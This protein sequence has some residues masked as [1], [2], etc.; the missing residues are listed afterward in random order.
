MS[1]AKR[2]WAVVVAS[3][4]CVLAGGLLVGVLHLGGGEMATADEASG[5]VAED[6]TGPDAEAYQGIQTLRQQLCLDDQ[7]LAAIG[8]SE[9]EATVVLTTLR[10]WYE[11]NH[12]NLRRIKAARSAATNALQDAKRRIAI[13]PRD[14]ALIARVPA[15]TAAAVEPIKQRLA[16]IKAA[17]QQIEATLTTERRGVWRVARANRGLRRRYRYIPSLTTIQRRTLMVA[18]R[19]RVRKLAVATSDAAPSIEAAYRDTEKNCLAASQRLAAGAAK[20]RQRTCAAGVRK[21]VEGVLTTPAELIEADEEP[22]T[23]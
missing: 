11:T 7:D 6:K 5:P 12:A 4:A 8:C 23:R 19:T 17:G 21:A 16:L 3:C 10:T 1:V 15:L 20:T 22:A 18:S 14:E 13:G 2:N 9:A